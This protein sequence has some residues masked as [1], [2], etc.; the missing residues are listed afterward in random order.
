MENGFV[1]LASI[2]GRVEVTQAQAARNREAYQAARAAR[3]RVTPR[4]LRPR[5]AVPALLPISR[6]GWWQGIKDGK[7][8]APVKVGSRSLWRATDIQELL[9]KLGRAA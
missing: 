8:P 2:L 5:S 9:E 3:E 1:D 6:S 7:Y 4:P